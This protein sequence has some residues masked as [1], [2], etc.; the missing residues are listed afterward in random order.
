MEIMLTVF[1]GDAR[2]LYQIFNLSIC[3]LSIK[4]VI[5]LRPRKEV[6]SRC[7]LVE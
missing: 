5:L 2:C 3:V 7:F 4:Y 6:N 1:N